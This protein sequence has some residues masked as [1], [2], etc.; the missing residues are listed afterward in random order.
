VPSFD[1]Y[2]PP[3]HLVAR[4]GIR[5]ANPVPKIMASVFGCQMEKSS[6]EVRVCSA[7]PALTGMKER[8]TTPRKVPSMKVRG[9]MPT[10]GEVTLMNQLGSKGVM[11]RKRM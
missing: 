11:R 2:C 7:S 1:E 10:W 5:A 4:V 9:G 3:S 8:G 6:N